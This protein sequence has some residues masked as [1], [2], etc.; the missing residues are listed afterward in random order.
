[1]T[2]LLRTVTDVDF[3]EIGS[4][5]YRSRAAAYADFL[6]PAALTFGSPAALAEWWTERWKWEQ[7][8]H[9][10]TVAVDDDAIVGF[11]YLGPSEEPGVRELGAIHVDPAYV[12]SGIGKLLMVD[13]RAHLGDRAVLW[14][15]EGNDRA[16]RFYERGGWVFDGTTREAPIGD[17]LTQQLRYYLASGSA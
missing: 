7:D 5:H 4:L 1:M 6:P 14:V 3:A 15:L 12:G 8:T 9:R 10:G 11:T 13:A 17:V 2:A 16:R